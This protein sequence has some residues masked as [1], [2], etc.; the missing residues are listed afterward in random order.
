M[1]NTTIV[2]RITT[3]AEYRAICE[4]VGWG[5]I[6]NF[7]AAPESLRRSLYGVI[8]LSGD[9]AVGMGR[10][11]GD[12]VMY[13]YIQDIAVLP[14][15]QGQ[16]IGTAIMDALMTWVRRTAAPQAFVGLFAA[17]AAI[18]FYRKYGFMI[19]PPDDLTGMFAV[20]QPPH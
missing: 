12:G 8:A 3:P 7:D 9:Q 17:P 16:G 20:I 10:V 13:F 18:R 11:V 5:S 2:S 14:A 1:L 6:I 19:P 15:Y 4:A